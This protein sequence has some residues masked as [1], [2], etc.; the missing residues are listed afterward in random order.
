M[1][2]VIVAAASVGVLRHDG[3]SDGSP[4]PNPAT[5]S[6]EPVGTPVIPFPVVPPASGEGVSSV[7]G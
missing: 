7:D 3:G 6:A 1:G 5:V 2:M 4:K